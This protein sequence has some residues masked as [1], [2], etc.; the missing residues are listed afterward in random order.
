MPGFGGYKSQ[1]RDQQRH[2]CEGRHQASPEA[3]TGVAT[4]RQ[5]RFYRR[6]SCVAG[7]LSIQRSHEAVA[8]TGNGFDE[9]GTISRIAQYLADAIDGF[10][11][12]Q[13]V[14]NDPVPWPVAL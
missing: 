5:R 13:I 2:R 7:S 14:I 3:G 10:L 8:A 9:V 11:Q 1:D 12:R 4:T 6:F